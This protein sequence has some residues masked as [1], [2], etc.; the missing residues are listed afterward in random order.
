MA[1]GAL[2]CESRHAGFRFVTIKSLQEPSELEKQMNQR[3]SLYLI[4]IK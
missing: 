4:T 1:L 3:F 2:L